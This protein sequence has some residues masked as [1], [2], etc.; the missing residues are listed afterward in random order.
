[1][2]DYHHSSEVNSNIDSIRGNLSMIPRHS[3]QSHHRRISEPDDVEENKND[4]NSE[5]HTQIALNNP[6][7]QN[8]L[9]E[10]PETVILTVD[11][12]LSQVRRK[13]ITKYLNLFILYFLAYAIIF[14]VTS[15]GI[16]Y[17]K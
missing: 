14:G 8:R 3:N 16:R 6:T 12:Q 9:P 17:S 5:I 2:I 13:Q 1:M 7:T 11:Q 4:Q 10:P 15:T